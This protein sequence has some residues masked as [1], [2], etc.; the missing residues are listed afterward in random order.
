MLGLVT[1]RSALAKFLYDLQ[2]MI[3]L[4]VPPLVIWKGRKKK[5]CYNNSSS[6]EGIF[7]SLPKK[8][9]Q[10]PMDI[11]HKISIDI[12]GTL[13]QVEFQGLLGLLSPEAGGG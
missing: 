3:R 9:I 2:A 6:K 4:S 7:L 12:P 13:T 1:P 11:P 10:V 8:L 5:R